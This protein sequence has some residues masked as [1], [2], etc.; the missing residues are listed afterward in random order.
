MFYNGG[1]AIFVD[2]TISSDKIP[3]QSL[4]TWQVQVCC[5]AE[6]F[7]WVAPAQERLPAGSPDSHLLSCLCPP[8]SDV[9]ALGILG[10]CAEN[11][12]LALSL[13]F[14]KRNTS[15]QNIFHSFNELWNS[16][17]RKGFSEFGC[18]DRDLECIFPQWALMLASF[19][20]FEANHF[21]GLL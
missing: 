1:F 18:R 10:P 9:Q 6:L 14:L 15:Q 20:I 13:C 19:Q 3:W 12:Y 2:R 17:I 8:A 4:I 16:M 7:W 11:L 21:Y 5:S